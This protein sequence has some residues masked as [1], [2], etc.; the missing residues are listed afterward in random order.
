MNAV[1]TAL[2]LVGLPLILIAV[3]WI[4]TLGNTNYLVPTPGGLL[5]AF[6]DTWFGDRFWRDVLPSVGRLLVGIAGSVILGVGL[7][8]LIG[9]FR[10]LRQVLEPLLEFFR[11][12]P[13]PVLVPVLALILGISDQMKIA[14]IIFGSMWP[15]LLN[16]IEGVRATD[17]VQRD[18]A[19]SYRLTKAHR[20][21]FLTLPAAAPQIM[22][23]VRQSLSI[24]LILMVIS[25]M[26]YSSSGLG[27]T[28]IQFQ[29][30]FAI[31]Q[32]WS[33]ILVLGL[34]GLALSLV[35][36][37]VERRVLAWYHGLR[38]VQRA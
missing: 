23:G 15:V 28:I 33:G 29:R 11:A 13:P 6:V 18:T 19:R 2:F 20:L 35:F 9:S 38:E 26:T 30:N 37:L 36:Q 27:F 24:A 3:W 21:Q 22:T 25:E 8:I 10:T 7:G 17:E 32:M 1:K 5:S 4:A 31:P 12:I 16:T 34:I 14:V